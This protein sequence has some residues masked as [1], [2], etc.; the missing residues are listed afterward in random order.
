MGK[1]IWRVPWG[2]ARG[3]GARR[4]AVAGR[5]RSRAPSAA[6]WGVDCRQGA[7]RGGR[8]PGQ[9]ERGLGVQSLQWVQ[10]KRAPPV[11]VHGRSCQRRGLAGPG[12]GLAPWDPGTQMCGAHP[13]PSPDANTAL[14]LL[15]RGGPR[16]PAVTVAPQLPLP[17]NNCIWKTYSQMSSCQLTGENILFELDEI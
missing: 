10:G 6:V 17:S 13:G 2:V 15:D 5:P 9:H 1:R 8:G 16:V 7:S 4:T 3:E 11:P 12:A 14:W